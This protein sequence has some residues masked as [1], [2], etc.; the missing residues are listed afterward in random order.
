MLWPMI[1]LH[2]V[3]VMKFAFLPTGARFIRPSV[4]ASVAKANAPRVSMIIF[5]QSNWTAV[6]GADP[7]NYLERNF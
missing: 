5:T 6:R 7:E 4:G 3:R 2:M 1:F